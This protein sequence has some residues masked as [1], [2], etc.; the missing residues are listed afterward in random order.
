MN[1][2]LGWLNTQHTAAV[3]LRGPCSS[4]FAAAHW[5]RSHGASETEMVGSNWQRTPNARVVT[6]PH[7]VNISHHRR[8]TGR[9]VSFAHQQTTVFPG[10]PTVS[11]SA[12]VLLGDVDNDAKAEIEL[13]VGGVDGT[14]AVFK[15]GYSTEGAY[16]IA[17]GMYASFHSS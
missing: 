12:A 9:S 13:V 1:P 7:S 10:A 5:R 3:T 2:E 8:E 15:A 14:L 4:S 6:A 11:G 17:S 16:L